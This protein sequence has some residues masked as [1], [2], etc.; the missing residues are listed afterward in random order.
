MLQPHLLLPA[1]LSRCG[2]KL[3]PKMMT[4]YSRLARWRN[5]ASSSFGARLQN[6][7]N[8]I[9]PS[10]LVSTRAI[11]T[12]TS[13]LNSAATKACHLW[14][15]IICIHHQSQVPWAAAAQGSL[16]PLSAVPTIPH[17][18]SLSAPSSPISTGGFNT[19]T[20]VHSDDGSHALAL[21]LH[22]EN[23]STNIPNKLRRK[24]QRHHR[25][26][27]YEPEDNNSGVRRKFLS[28]EGLWGHSNSGRQKEGK[29]PSKPKDSIRLG[30]S[31]HPLLILYQDGTKFLLKA[32]GT[33]SIRI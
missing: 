6:I 4:K 30:V 21:Q 13:I 17:N 27:S 11:L 9:R 10:S 12:L 19:P 32:R 16:S 23:F 26:R 33:W 3:S 7:S 14:T 8:S 1:T 15:P 5:A 22:Q 2:Q 20:S 31:N 18:M 25:G 28:F 24:E 29:K